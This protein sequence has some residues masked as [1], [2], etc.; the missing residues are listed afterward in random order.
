MDW[1]LDCILDCILDR[2]LDLT[3]YAWPRRHVGGRY[4]SVSVDAYGWG[5]RGVATLRSAGGGW[6]SILQDNLFL[7]G[8]ISGIS[9]PSLTHIS[10]PSGMQSTVANEK[11][12]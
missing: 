2:I 8:Q 3:S 12:T 5:R 7:L 4:I 11:V 10:L 6:G 1:T 9:D